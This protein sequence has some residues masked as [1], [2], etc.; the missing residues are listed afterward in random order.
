MKEAIVIQKKFKKRL[1]EAIVKTVGEASCSPMCS[2]LLMEK[3]IHTKLWI[4]GSPK[5]NSYIHT[6]VNG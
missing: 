4:T 1:K 2:I 5:Q 6:P 3:D